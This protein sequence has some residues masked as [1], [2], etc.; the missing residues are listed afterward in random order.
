MQR[1]NAILAAAG[2]LALASAS[3]AHAGA[4]LETAPLLAMDAGGSLYCQIRNV[5]PAPMQIT[6]EGIDFGG[7]VVLSH[8]DTFAAGEGRSRLAAG[9]VA[10]RCRFKVAGSAKRV[11]AAAVYFDGAEYT[12]AL[13]A[14]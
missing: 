9:P 6:V 14:R 3:A 2:A 10:T 5:G 11:R 12:V 7:D 1:W 13:P 8:T 4:T